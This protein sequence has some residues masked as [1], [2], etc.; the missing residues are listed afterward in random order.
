MNETILEKLRWRYA[1][2]KFDPER[3]IPDSDWEALEDALVLTPSSYGLQPWKF[4]VIQDQEL[5][6][7]LVA[8]SYNQRQVADCSHLLV[9][10]VKTTI[11]EEDVDHYVETASSAQGIEA[12]SLDYYRNLIIGDIVRGPRS[13]DIPGWAKLQ[14]YIALGNFM[15]CA[16]MIGVDTCPMEGFLPHAFDEALGLEEHGL[17]TAVLCPA[18]YRSGEDKYSKSDKVRYGKEELIERIG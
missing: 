5:Q 16:A 10:T 15:T 4:Y 18:G 2:K 12:E 14:S 11:T 1:T 7:S 13:G 6:D 3:K 8:S 9:I 17:T